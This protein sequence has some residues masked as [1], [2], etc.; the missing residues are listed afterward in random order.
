MRDEPNAELRCRNTRSSDTTKGVSSSRQPDGGH[1][2][3]NPLRSV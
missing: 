1:G 3:R 2:S